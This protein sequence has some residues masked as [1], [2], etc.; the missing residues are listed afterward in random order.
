[1]L[2]PLVRQEAQELLQQGKERNAVAAQLGLKS[3]TLRKAIKAGR[4]VE[5]IKKSE[6][7]ADK[8]QRSV[9]DSQAVM[10]MGCVRVEERVLAAFGGL[11]QAPTRLTGTGCELRG[12]VVGVAGLAGQWIVAP[13]GGVF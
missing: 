12:C 2:T 1:M 13:R 3:D 8:S 4:I 10:G 7:V 9:L 6:A 11:V 5:P